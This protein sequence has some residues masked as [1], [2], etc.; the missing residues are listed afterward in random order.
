MSTP[1]PDHEAIRD[2]LGA[3][4]LGAVDDDERTEMEAHL[5]S[6]ASCRDELERH[7]IAVAGLVRMAAELGPDQAA[8]LMDAVGTAP[9]GPH[10]RPRPRGGRR[11]VVG[12]RSELGIAALLV[13]LVS[14]ATFAL[15]TRQRLNRVEGRLARAEQIEQVVTMATNPGTRTAH[16]STAVEGVSMDVIVLA[17]GNAMVWKNRLP[18]LSLQRSYFL[19]AVVTGQ[20]VPIGRI[21]PGGKP[22]VVQVPSGAG[23]LVVTDE[24][25]SGPPEG[26]RVVVAGGLGG[27]A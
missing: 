20:R 21:D 22:Q 25:A 4:A 19:W 5:Q 10:G 12:W 18:A 7:A 2:L 6:C 15:V 9:S 23:G 26:T 14:A 3:Y 27:G 11:V 1:G 16:L 24:R 13:V 17:D 8:N